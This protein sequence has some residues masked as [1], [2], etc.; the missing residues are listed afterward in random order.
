MSELQVS[1]LT[2]ARIV[3]KLTAKMVEV[4]GKD[5]ILGILPAHA[6]LVAE[7]GIGE[8]KVSIDNEQHVYFVAGGYIEVEKDEVKVL[9]DVAERPG[10]INVKRAEQ[11][12]ARAL[13]RLNQKAGTDVMRAQASLLRAEARLTVAGRQK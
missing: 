4:P 2:P 3:G 9:A 7:L 13:D 11:A 8:I 1:I 12:K 10:D 6:R 5:G